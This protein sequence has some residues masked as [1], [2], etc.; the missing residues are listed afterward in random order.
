MHLTGWQQSTVP[1]PFPN[2]RFCS[3]E[4]SEEK[5]M[6]SGSMPR[7][8][9]KPHQKWCVDQTLRTRGIP[10]R[11]LDRDLGS[12][13]GVLANHLGNVRVATLDLLQLGLDHAHLVGVLDKTLG[14]RVAADDPLPPL[15][16]RHLAPGSSLAVRE[17]DIDKG[18][19][20]VAR[21]PVANRVLV[22]G[23][24]V[25]QQLDG[26]EAAEPGVKALL[27]PFEGTQNSADGPCLSGVGMNHDLRVGHLAGDKGPLSL[28]H[29]QVPVG[30]AL[31]HK[32]PSHG[33]QI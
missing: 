21:T 2:S 4:V 18:A 7:A 16:Q 14:A 26:V 33:P 9:R 24:G 8:V 29:R 11:R 1:R 19:L 12:A 22:G 30:S 13:V 15:R 6:P 17:T 10:T 3:S 31:E 20:A 25:C 23:A 5:T 32:L 28:D 27:P